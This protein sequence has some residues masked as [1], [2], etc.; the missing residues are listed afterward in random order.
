MFINVSYVIIHYII[1]VYNRVYKL[2]RQAFFLFC[3]SPFLIIILLLSYIFNNINITISIITFLLFLLAKPISLTP[4]KHSYHAITKKYCK[5]SIYNSSN[6]YELKLLPALIRFK[7]WQYWVFCHTYFYIYDVKRGKNN[8]TL[9]SNMEI[10]DEDVN[11]GLIYT[12]D[13]NILF[14]IKEADE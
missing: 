5:Q 13:K 3:F 11:K 2:F 4:L 6:D 12:Y 7:H 14:Y 1:V 8:F 10:N 9:Y